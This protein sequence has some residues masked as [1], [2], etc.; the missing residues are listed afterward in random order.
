MLRVS[1]VLGN[2]EYLERL[3]IWFLSF[4]WISWQPCVHGCVQ[5]FMHVHYMTCFG[6]WLCTEIYA[7]YDLWPTALGHGCAHICACWCT[8]LRH[9]QWAFRYSTSFGQRALF[10]AQYNWGELLSGHQ[11]LW[12]VT[13]LAFCYPMCN[14]ACLKTPWYCNLL[15]LTL[16]HILTPPFACCLCTSTACLLLSL[17]YIWPCS[18]F[19]LCTSAAWLLITWLVL[20]TDLLSV[21]RIVCAHPV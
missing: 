19:W 7:L 12:P 1:A 20:A 21:P 3:N 6:L 15:L 16:V 8:W 11:L 18:C 17:A 2:I 14:Q 4:P 9:V 13:W 5:R 10:K